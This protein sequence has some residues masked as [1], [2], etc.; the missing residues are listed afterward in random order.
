MPVTVIDIIKPNGIPIGQSLF[1]TVEDIDILGGFQI[2]A[3]AAG[4]LAIPQVN[5]KIGMLVYQLDNSTYYN[6]TVIGSPGTWVIATFSGGGGFTAGGDLSGSSSSQTVIQIHGAT[7]PIAGSLITNTVLQ[8]SAASTLTYA[9]LIDANISS[10]AAIS[11]TKINPNFGSQTITTSG[12]IT[13]NSVSAGAA[14]ISGTLTAASIKDT[15]ISIAG[16]VLTDASGNFSSGKINLA[17]STYITGI[18]PTVNQAN[19]TMVGDVSG[20]TGSATVIKLQGNN[21]LAQTLNSI[22]DGYVLTWINSG[23]N[24]QARPSAGSGFIA[25]GDLLGTSSSQ[26]VVKLNGNPIAIQTLGTLQDGYVITWDFTDG[27]YRAAPAIGGGGGG[28]PTGAARGNLAGTYPNPLVVFNTPFFFTDLISILPSGTRSV[29]TTDGYSSVNDG[30]GGTFIW[31]TGTFLTNGG[32]I[33]VP[34]GMAGIGAWI[35]QLHNN[36]YNVRYFGAKGDAT[37]GQVGTDDTFAIQQTINAV[38]ANGSG[39]LYFGA[40]L[41]R[42]DATQYRTTYPLFTGGAGFDVTMDSEI[43]P[44]PTVI[45]PAFVSGDQFPPPT[46]GTESGLTYAAMGTSGNYYDFTLLPNSNNIQNWGNGSISITT[47]SY[48]Q[49]PQLSTVVIQVAD[50]Y[51]FTPWFAISNQLYVKGGG[52]YLYSIV[53]ATHISLY[54]LQPILAGEATPGNTVASG[55]PV[56]TATPGLT[57][58]C[59]VDPIADWGVGQGIG[60]LAC[61]ESKLGSLT[62][63]SALKVY[64]YND[65]GTAQTRLGF[66][67]NTTGSGLTTVLSGSNTIAHGSLTH[68]AAVYDGYNTASLYIAGTRVATATVTGPIIQAWYEQFLLGNNNA[69][70]QFPGVTG[71]GFQTFRMA[72]PSW[73]GIAKYSGSSFTP[74]A[75]VINNLTRMIGTTIDFAQQPTVIGPGGANF[76]TGYVLAKTPNPAYS[77]TGSTTWLLSAGSIANNYLSYTGMP[78]FKRCTI[79]GT[80]CAIYALA[81]LYGEVSDSNIS[82]S[83]QGIILDGFSYNNKIKDNQIS[84]SITSSGAGAC[85]CVLG[86]S[87]YTILDGGQY[88]GGGWNIINNVY[89]GIMIEN[90]WLETVGLGGILLNGESG[91]SASIRNC[92]LQDDFGRNPNVPLIA[93]VY[94]SGI[95]HFTWEGGYCGLTAP[96][97]CIIVDNVAFG[98]IKSVSLFAFSTALSAITFINQNR[99]F[100]LESVQALFPQFLA[101]VYATFTVTNGSSS[102]V[103]S[104]SAWATSMSVNYYLTF[105]SQINTIYKIATINSTTGNF[106][107]TVPYSGVTNAGVTVTIM[108]APWMPETGA[109]GQGPLILPNQE[110]FGINIVNMISA[111]GMTLLINDFLFKSIKITDTN[112][113]LSS[114]QKIIL[115][116]IAGYT[117]A[118]VNST[119]QTLTFG[120]A[121]GATVNIVATGNGTIVCDG[122]NWITVA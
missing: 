66:K 92:F 82:G 122:T 113:L 106:T 6:L 54:F 63:S 111:T 72:S 33:I 98:S 1:P 91:P 32:T 16:A 40:N 69:N 80:Q 46:Y 105:S 97:P 71:D 22:Q 100:Q 68:I 37:L 108:G 7:V 119:L 79:S 12:T 77:T 67:I 121:T 47:A 50:G 93:G 110:V 64:L 83:F 104:T 20:T 89:A 87:Q 43:T 81:S 15:G 109:S 57:F 99:P 85:V 10:S 24:W 74:P 45:N 48:V 30:G 19:Q 8:V 49:P 88:D 26:T 31:T 9:L 116:L 34:T 86:G 42:S 118:F 23:A 73:C 38:I 36:Y 59:Y 76:G 58:E 53:D 60:F 114:T 102:I 39:T 4:R 28:A 95:Q 78:H 18:L 65:Q 29:L 70:G 107:T 94:A 90:L 13:A 62:K 41:L 61:S 25:G 112:N 11:G 115:P 21:V 5:Q 101:G 51:A 27:Y 17:S 55:S 52:L 56:G 117:R 75:T 14:G 120:G 35:R 96:A 44:D 103:A 3:N 84:S 2:Q